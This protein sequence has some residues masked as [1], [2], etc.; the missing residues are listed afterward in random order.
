MKEITLTKGM[1]TLVDDEDYVWLSQWAW[2]AK[3]SKSCWYAIRQSKGKII[4][5]HREIMKPEAHLQID[6]IN[7]NS[8]DNR[9]EN[10]RICTAAENN[11]NKSQVQDAVGIYLNRK[12]WVAQ[13]SLR[14]FNSF[15]EAR[16][17]REKAIAILTE[18]GFF[19]NHK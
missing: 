8:L 1:V 6:H 18:A 15:E 19:N 11:L 14:G 12:R 10:L 13:V 7:R 4:R 16:E 5:M 2:S 3:Q 9:R 17:S